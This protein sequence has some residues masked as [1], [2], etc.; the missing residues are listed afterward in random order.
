MRSGS[1]ALGALAV[2]ATCP[3]PAQTPRGPGESAPSPVFGKPYF[4]ENVG[5]FPR[6]DI[7]FF[8]KSPSVEVGFAN[9]RVF[10]NVL[11]WQTGEE[12]RR[13]HVGGVLVEQRVGTGTAGPEALEPLPGR[14]HYFLGPDESRWKRNVRHFGKILYRNA[15][16]GVDLVY[17]FD[18]R[19]QLTYEF[20][21]RP[22]ADPGSIA[23]SYE[24]VERVVPRG[25]NV[26][27]V[28]TSLGSLR[29]GE[30]LCY[31]EREGRRSVVASRFRELGERAYGLELLEDY[32][33]SRPLVVDPTLVFSTYWGAGGGDFRTV[34]ID[35]SGNVYGAGDAGGSTWPTTPG[36]YDRTHNSPGVWPDA[37]AVKFDPNGNVIWSTL[38]GGPSEDYVYVSAVDANEDLYLAG[39]AGT[40]FPTTLGAFDRSFNGGILIPGIHDATDGFVTKL[41]RNGDSLVYSTYIGGNGNDIARGIHLFPSGDVVV[42]G[43]NSESTNMP[44]TPGAFRSAR[45]GVKDAYVARLSASGG[46][47]VF[48]TYFGSS[49][50]TSSS[51]DETIRALG[52]D[53]A[54]NIWV[55]GT[56][57][58]T[59]FT[60]T[61]N[62]FQPAHRG[63]GGEAYVAKLSPDG[64]TLVYFSWLGGTAHE[65]VETEGVTDSAGNFY[66]CGG[67]KSADFPVTAGAFQTV[68]RGG[69]GQWDG[70]GWVARINNNGTLGFATFLGGSV[71]NQCFGPGLDPSGNV[72]VSGA[73]N[74]PD[75]PVTP[76]AHQSALAGSRDTFLSILSGDG[77]RLLYG[78]YFGGTADDGG[79]YVAV[80]PDGSTVALVGATQSTNY[81]LRNAAQ[82]ALNG[83]GAA[84]LTV[85]DVRD[86]AGTSPSVTFSPPPPSASATS[87]LVVTGT[88]SGGTVTSVTWAN[89]TTGQSGTATGTT[90]WTST[91]PLQPGPNTI[92]ITVMNSSG[93]S[94]GQTFTVT[95]TPGGPGPSGSSGGDEGCG[96]TGLEVLLVLGFVGAFRRRGSP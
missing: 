32:D 62:A 35:A 44:V 81:P 15:Y 91:I 16:P 14:S 17:F 76:N 94:S 96:A 31:Q 58:G 79:R 75:F 38:I 87:P 24:G 65:E 51:A 10:F 48:C 29:D 88:A 20:N 61:S 21:V 95:Y 18:E 67:T 90:N 42:S 92:T 41:S 56:T 40:G 19:G 77:R 66:I 26:M 85:F 93:G 4:V 69:P 63:G 2:L 22:G 53:A 70:C 49:N 71:R 68:Y 25:T 86:L 55:A 52:A 73:T 7:R 43:G 47:L 82:T 64:K 37:H 13:V 30:L 46:S 36:A 28:V 45:A 84:Y 74:S 34:Q 50:D 60:P 1:W 33:R 9:G 23:M 89:A 27:E 8:M 11:R 3:R 83:N 54:G 57:S 12:D 5:Q 6:D 72:Y 39:R 80:H 78:T 59:G